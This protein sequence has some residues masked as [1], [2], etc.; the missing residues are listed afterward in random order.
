MPISSNYTENLS[1]YATSSNALWLAHLSGGSINVSAVSV[2]SSVSSFSITLTNYATWQSG[3]EIFTK[4][5]YGI[6]GNSEPYP[7]GALLTVNGSS[8]SD[9]TSLAN[10]LGQQFGLAFVPLS[11]TA[12]SF[13]FFS[14]SD[15]ATELQNY[16]YGLVPK[17]EGGFAA[18]FSESQLQSNGLNYFEL[19]YSNSIYSLTFGGIL[20]LSSPNFALYSQLGLASASYN[21]SSVS[22]SSSV[23]VFVL[24][25]LIK[26]SAEPFTNHL[27]NISSN[28]QVQRSNNN[29]IPDISANLDFSFP[30][31]VAYR[32]VTPT[33]T[34]GS[35]TS[36]TVSVTVKNISPAGGATAENVFV[37]DSW[38]YSQGSN[39]H[40]T[41]TNTANN[42]TLAPENSYT[43]IYAFTVSASSGTF[44]IPATPVTY[45]YSYSNSSKLNGE[46]TLNP[47]ELA[48]GATN[49]PSLE[50]IATLASGIQIQSGQSYAVNVTVVN[51]G[52]GSAFGVSS[53]GLSKGTLAPGSSWSFISNESSSSL[54]QTNANLSFSVNWQD[55][56]G[57]SH[58]TTTNSINIVLGF[59]APGSP[60]LTIDKSV[61]LPVSNNLNVTLSVFNGS[62][63]EL[64]G[65]TLKDLIPTGLSFAKSY[66]ASSIQAN[67]QSVEGNLSSIAPQGVA[68]FVY[69]LTVNNPNENYVFTPANIT[70]QW[71]NEDITHFSGGYG[72]PLGVQ[73]TKQFSPPQGFQGSNVSVVLEVANNGVLPIFNVNLNSN[74]ASFLTILNS[75]TK[76]APILTNGQKLSD[77]FIA[78]LTG[79]PGSYNS[80]SA[81]ASFIF[82]GTEQTAT[83]S[84]ISIEIFHLPTANLTYSAQKVEEGHDIAITVTISNPSNF[85][86]TDI[87]YT[88][89]IPNN[90]RVLS[91]SQ[92]N[93]AIASLGPHA[94]ETHTFTVITNQPY[95]YSLNDTKL[96]F[97]YQGH[98][99]SGITGGLSLNIGDDVPLRYGI[100]GVI[101]IIIVVAT[102]L[103]IRRLTSTHSL[104]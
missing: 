20:A 13:T 11:S 41:Q 21:Y 88:L 90:L 79:A 65:V 94:N 100:P 1:V 76:S 4:Y 23:D 70:A 60:A 25:G 12:A 69:E 61:S 44:E 63:Q 16:F 59:A 84:A 103:Y 54:T 19:S 104:K 37:N 34:P 68:V 8:S 53:G 52:D 26:N 43:V 15:Y 46:V 96:T 40:L 93:F 42:Q 5:G 18:M 56:S 28:I 89:T 74:F 98:Q 81:G 51:K 31:I 83:S 27:A 62:P 33:L 73:I 82:A 99:L 14:P 80:S 29:T 2:P 102:V 87:S 10:S 47:E 9:A 66:N 92:A 22:T 71:N 91:G 72:L 85:T 35:G 38:I 50:A 45:Q 32:Q 101:G 95:G 75:S 97:S 49:T 48:V 77:V 6:L 17:S 64:S 24:G 36:V 57:T 86:L 7:N 67:G 3:Y 58:S 78:N 55:A 30:T 39:F